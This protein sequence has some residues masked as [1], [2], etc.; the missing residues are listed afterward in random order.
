MARKGKINSIKTESLLGNIEYKPVTTSYP[1][2]IFQG[3]SDWV[4]AYKSELINR[5]KV[6]KAVSIKKY[7][8]GLYNEFVNFNND[9][10]NPSWSWN[11]D[12]L[13]ESDIWTLRD[14]AVL[15]ENGLELSKQT[16]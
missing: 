15:L 10:T 7:W 13:E 11:Q 4:S 2:K 1:S 16:F 6:F 3:E 9:T 5:L 8:G 14:M 12:K